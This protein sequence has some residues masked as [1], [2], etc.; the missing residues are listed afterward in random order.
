MIFSAYKK[1]YHIVAKSI[2]SE[3][4]FLGTNA[5]S[6][7]YLMCDVGQVKLLNTSVPWVPLPWD[8]HDN[9]PTSLSCSE[10]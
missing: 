2:S 8:E 7:C 10:D 3:S 6:R 1:Y 9:M 4:R 5:S